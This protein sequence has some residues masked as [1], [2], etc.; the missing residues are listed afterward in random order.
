MNDMFGNGVT[1][2]SH[3]AI[4]HYDR[5]VDAHLHAWPGVLESV[6]AALAEAPDFSLPHALKHWCLRVADRGRKLERP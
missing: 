1:C 4:Q 2:V 5:A 3:A 6:D